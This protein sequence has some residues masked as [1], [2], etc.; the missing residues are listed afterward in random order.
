MEQI[1]IYGKGGVGKSVV[2][3]NLSA[4]CARADHKVLH[5]G[6]DPKRDSA[7]RLVDSATAL[8]TV[9]DALGD[10]PGRVDLRDFLTTGRLNIDCCESGGPQPG[11]GCAGRGVARCLEY[12]AEIDLFRTGAYDLV[13]YD[14][15]GDV[16]CG[17]FAAP[18][19]SGFARKVFIVTSEEPMSLYAANNISKAVLT[20]QDNGVVL[21]GLVVNLRRNDADRDGL[22][23]FAALLSTRV[24]AFVERDE[25]IIEAERNMRTLVEFAPESPTAASLRQLAT[26]M[27]A[28][29]A[30]Q[31]PAPSPLS[32]EEFFRFIRDTR[33]DLGPAR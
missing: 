17:G 12:L 5:I 6:C 9:L 31:T 10:N 33:L 2:A 19:R 11:V 29:D 27:L 28:V 22:R 1:A 21:G 16:V 13:V 15:L 23:V 8:P 7:V 24:L 25:R 14:V 3:T 30:A 26:D 4:C 20:Y 18:L 32:D